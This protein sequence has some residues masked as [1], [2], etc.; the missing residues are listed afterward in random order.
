MF[1]IIKDYIK[2][3]SILIAISILIVMLL[4]CAIGYYIGL[5][6]CNKQLESIKPND[7]TR[8]TQELLNVMREYHE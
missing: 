4:F 5:Y 2:S 3:F 8:S 6:T 7:D 1:D